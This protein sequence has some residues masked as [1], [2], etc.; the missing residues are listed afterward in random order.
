MQG[1]CC[2]FDL[3]PSGLCCFSGVVDSCGVCSGTNNCEAAVSVAVSLSDLSGI[4]T[5]VIAALLNVDPILVSGLVLI[6][7]SRR[8]G[9]VSGDGEVGGTLDDAVTVLRNQQG[10]ELDSEDEVEQH[11]VAAA[12]GGARALRAV[13]RQ[14]RKGEREG[15]V[16]CTGCA[17]VDDGSVSALGTRRGGSHRRCFPTDVVGQLSVSSLRLHVFVC[18]HW[19]GN[20][21][22]DDPVV[23]IVV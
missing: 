7:G 8:L 1:N 5:T 14:L 22:L 13:S 15:D 12:S 4:N 16:G 2:P 3:P 6:N 20:P 10:R 21:E 9:V 19:G 23:L 11:A 18:D 17:T